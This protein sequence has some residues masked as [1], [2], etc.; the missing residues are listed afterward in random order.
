MTDAQHAD[1]VANVFRRYI[2]RR[3]GQVQLRGFRVELGEIEA[4]LAAAPGV[5]GVAVVLQDKDTPNAALIAYVEPENVDKDALLTA[6]GAKLP[7]YMVPAVIVKL[8][9]LPQLP[10][11]KVRQLPLGLLGLL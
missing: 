8:P 2:C 5:R 4:V 10:N 6:C 11:G 3:D 9:Q 7:R 1:D